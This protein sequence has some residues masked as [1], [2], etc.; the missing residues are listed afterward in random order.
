[1]L[2]RASPP[3]NG[4]NR[5][6]DPRC[7]YR[8]SLF[9][10]AAGCTRVQARSCTECVALSPPALRRSISCRLRRRPV[11]PDD[12]RFPLEDIARL[13]RI[14]CAPTTGNSPEESTGRSA[15]ACAIPSHPQPTADAEFAARAGLIGKNSITR[16]TLRRYVLPS[17]RSSPWL[18]AG[19]SEGPPVRDCCW[20]RRM[21]NSPG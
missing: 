12:Y 4:C 18:R 9:A 3:E 15:N 11:H 7:L 19:R 5:R 2:Q 13:Q 21:P 6:G 10:S 8:Q 14:N 1:M 17:V 16:S 20:S